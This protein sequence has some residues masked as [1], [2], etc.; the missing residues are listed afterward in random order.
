MDLFE[1]DILNE[2]EKNKKI[3]KI[4]L[5]SIIIVVILCIA[6]FG[7]IVYLQSLKLKVDIDGVRTTIAD[8]LFIID[9]NGKVYVSI[10]DIATLLQ[11]EYFNGEYGKVSED[12]TKCYVKSKDEIATFEANSERIYKTPNTTN[13]EYEYYDVSEP[14]R[15]INEKL[16]IISDGV[17]IAFNSKFNY[18][19][20]SNTITIFS[21]PYLV[22]YYT[23][24]I[25]NYGYKELSSDFANQKAL[26][27]DMIVAKK[28]TG[29]YGVITA[30]KKEILGAKYAN[31][32]FIENTKDFFVTTSAKKMGLMSNKAEPKINDEYDKIQLLDKDLELYLVE[33]NSRKGVVDKNGKIVIYLEYDDIGLEKVEQY[34][35]SDI[36]NRYLLFDNCI[37]VKQNDKWGMFDKTGKLIL[38]IEYD[39]FGY[40]VSTSKDKAVNNLAVIPEYE[41][42]VICKD[43]KYG[44]VNSIGDIIIPVALDKIYSITSSGKESFEMEYQ[45]N[46]GDVIQYLEAHN[47]PKANYVKTNTGTGLENITVNNQTGNTSNNNVSSTNTTNEDA[48]NNNVNNGIEEDTRTE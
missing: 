23:T 28:D 20:K 47:V 6:I 29:S 46:T 2:R 4:T 16:Y 7:A 14:V 37:I 8:D 5:I 33:N 19:Q 26:V 39:R 36:K 44:L 38:P 40:I 10:K 1:N 11:Y 18:N 30:D 45:G 32:E 21:L 48:S 43:K 41:A 31:I 9:E 42:I 25:L 34:K 15:I 27:Y 13:I 3:A 12:A 22:Q 24:N 35:S 17:T